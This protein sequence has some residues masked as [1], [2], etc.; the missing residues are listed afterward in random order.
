MDIIAGRRDSGIMCGEILFDGKPR[1]DSLVGY[2]QSFDVHIGEMTVLQ[3]LYYSC[4]L[5]VDPNLSKSEIES[6]CRQI[7]AL[8]GLESAL[9]TIVG[10][11]LIKGISGGQKKLLTIATELLSNPDVIFLDEV[12][13]APSCCLI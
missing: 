9:D 3:N 7:A 1:N 6:R 2:V 5:R 11:I 10:N 12:C 8:V 13:G 4:Q